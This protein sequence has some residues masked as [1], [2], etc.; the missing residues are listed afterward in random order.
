MRKAIACLTTVLLSLAAAVPAWAD[1]AGPDDCTGKSAGAACYNYD[2][3]QSG[4]C[5]ADSMGM[6]ACDVTDTGSSGTGGAGTTS[7]GTA[8]E[9]GEGGQSGGESSASSGCSVR[10]VRAN[11][12]AEAAGLALLLAACVAV[13]RRRRDP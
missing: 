10:Q 9:G 5:K 2:L 7:T 12:G 1:G 3:K 8:G 6:L 11:G 4:V 13:Q